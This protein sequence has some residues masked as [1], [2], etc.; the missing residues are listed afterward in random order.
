[1]PIQSII[2][3]EP[4]RGFSRKLRFKPDIF[5]MGSSFPCVSVTIKF[6]SVSQELAMS[7]PVCALVPVTVTKSVIPAVALIAFFIPILLEIPLPRPLRPGLFRRSLPGC[8]SSLDSLSRTAIF[9]IA[10]LV[11]VVGRRSDGVERKAR[12]GEAGCVASGV[13]ERSGTGF[14]LEGDAEGAVRT[15]RSHRGYRRAKM[16]GVIKG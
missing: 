1:M 16:R 8:E 6:P 15:H 2:R 14:G 9:C 3:L 12:V 11:R 10:G 4:G 13:G 7:S 5:S